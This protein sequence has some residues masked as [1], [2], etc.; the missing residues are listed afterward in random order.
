M[1]VE[2]SGVVGGSI[3]LLLGLEVRKIR[4]SRELIDF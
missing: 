2:G 4:S 3:A 1:T